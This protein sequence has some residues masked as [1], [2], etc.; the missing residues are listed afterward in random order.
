MMPIAP[1]L[2]VTVDRLFCWLVAGHDDARL[3]RQPMLSQ[4]R[5]SGL[6]QGNLDDVRAWNRVSLLED[7]TTAGLIKT[8][9]APAAPTVAALP[10]ASTTVPIGM[11]PSRERQRRVQQFSGPGRGQRWSNLTTSIDHRA[12]AEG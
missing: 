10:A 7:G 12:Q 5:C 2:L 3:D 6:R 11:A 9:A 4:R 8:Q 1:N